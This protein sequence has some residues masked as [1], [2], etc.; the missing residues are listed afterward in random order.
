ML[1]LDIGNSRSKWARVEQGAWLQSG[2]HETAELD[3]LCLTLAAL[4]SPGRVLVSNVAGEQAA[5]QVR[6]LC[7]D[8]GLVPEFVRASAQQCGV[9][10]GYEQPERLGS[11]RWAALLA[12]WQHAHGA[13]L[14]VNCGTATTVDALSAHGEFLGG[15]ILPGMQMMRQALV[16]N[17]AQ[18]RDD[19]GSLRD[20]PRNTAD[21][22]YSGA[23][24]ATLGAIR[25]QHA[26][27]ADASAPCLLSG[28][29]AVQLPDL[30][31]IQVERID[32]L[33]LQGLQVIGET[34]AC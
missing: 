10:N 34:G 2:A 7:R 20:F 6:A 19:A 18:L 14:V 4:R 15:L 32:N 11:D 31:G 13:C 21:A 17:T 3:G 5:D 27:L 29:A 24:A 30:L 12:A 28:G 8:W 23:I 1:L 9:R 26:L 16:R 25:Q 33:V 22:I